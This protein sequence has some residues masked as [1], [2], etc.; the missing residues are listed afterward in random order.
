MRRQ[1]L[2]PLLAAQP[3]RTHLVAR[4]VAQK[5]PPFQG[6]LQGPA[7]LA[8]QIG[9]VKFPFNLPRLSMTIKTSSEGV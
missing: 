2:S 6:G 9:E 1:S 5:N 8:T 4:P 7:R 3:R